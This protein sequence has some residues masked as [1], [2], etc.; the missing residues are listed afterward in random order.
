[1]PWGSSPQ[2]AS[3]GRH[4]PRRAPSGVGASRRSSRRPRSD[5]LGGSNTPPGAAGGT[6]REWQRREPPG[7]LHHLGSL[8]HFS[9]LLQARH[10]LEHAK[11]L[12]R[13]EGSEVLQVLRELVIRPLGLDE[14]E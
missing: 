11:T 9:F 2:A 1:M 8:K 14:R 4:P 6:V 10:D 7:S 13:K 3:T 12:S 5:G